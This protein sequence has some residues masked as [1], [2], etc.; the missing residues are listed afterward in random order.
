MP[1]T[2]RPARTPGKLGRRRLRV[3]LVDDEVAFAN[4]VRQYLERTGRYDV[5]CLQLGREA[6][7][8][9]HEWTPEVVLLDYML[10]DLDGGQVYQLL[11]ADPQLRRIP[12]ILLT[13]LASHDSPFN[14]AV[15]SKRFTL[16]KPVE[17]G[18]LDKAIQ[19]LTEA[20]S[21]VPT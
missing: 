8:V 3:L 1:V 9:A 11:K 18:A 7:S 14:S 5:R 2:S 19:V 6:L 21:G 10:P 4:S 17:F 15:R 12:I 16:S 13:G 20:D